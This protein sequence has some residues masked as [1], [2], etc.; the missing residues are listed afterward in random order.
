MTQAVAAGFVWQLVL[1]TGL[2][3]WSRFGV[4]AVIDAA[5]QPVRAVRWQ[6]HPE[7]GPTP[8]PARFKWY[9]GLFGLAALPVGVVVAGVCATWRVT[10]G[11]W[12][13]GPI[14]ETGWLA[15]ILGWVAL[16][17]AGE[18]SI[19]KELGAEHTVRSALHRHR[20]RHIFE[21]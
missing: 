15:A 8:A 19:A 20:H 17:L 6:P 3:Y 12:P 2:I 7:L 13:P 18:L 1:L 21:R 5:T 4:A 11:A 9:I 14:V 16:L 10:V